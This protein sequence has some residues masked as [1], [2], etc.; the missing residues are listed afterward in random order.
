MPTQIKVPAVGE[1]IKSVYV[2]DWKKNTGDYCNAGDII[3]EIETDKAS[4]EI[5]T[6]VA[7]VI[8]T[9][10]N[11]GDE[12]PIG[13]VLASID[14]A[15]E[16]PA[17]SDKP[18]ATGSE[19]ALGQ[20]E[21]PAPVKPPAPAEDKPLG[22]ATEVLTTPSAKVHAEELGIDLG[23]VTGS[24]K[25]GRILKEDVLAA[26]EEAQA[27][28]PDTPIASNDNVGSAPEPVAPVA[29]PA[30]IGE[31]TRKRMS[32]MRRTIANRLVS[33]QHEA[34]MLTTFN[35]ADMS[36]IIDLRKKCQKEFVETHGVKLGF[37]SLFVKAV[38]RALKAV[39]NVNAAIDGTDIVQYHRQHIGVAISTEKGLVVPVVRDAD[40]L[41]LAEIE[42][43]IIAYAEKAR[44][45]NIDLNDLTGGT[46]SI[47]NGG[48]F[49]SMMSTPILNPPQSGILG[50]HT[51]Q[52]RPVALNGQ[53][54]IRPMMYLALT[55]DHRIVDGREAVTFLV[56]VKEFIENPALGL[57]D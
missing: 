24:G 17:K 23:S 33:A 42:K 36:Q 10:A 51:I 40:N 55:Y 57:V 14:E 52:E 20:T 30:E 34:A 2:A 39:P 53:V 7:G 32:M 54:V 13:G 6:E 56:K 50:M 37:M 22:Q 8:T 5:P 26:A 28:A 4:Q 9:Q 43:A 29:A 3:C 19:P 44:S 45:G 11:I 21:T 18:A 25:G 49:G 16:A 38:V 1:S 47:T 27:T 12:L 46:F 15:G 41:S 35:E 48:I 31:V